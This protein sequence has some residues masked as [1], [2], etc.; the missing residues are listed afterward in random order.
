MAWRSIG[1]IYEPSA[2]HFA[3]HTH[4]SLPTAV[5]LGGDLVR[6]FYSGQDP[7][8]RFAIGS[9]VVRIGEAPVIE[10][11][12]A[13]PVL[14][15]GQVGAFDDAGCSMGCVVEISEPDDRLYYMGW[16]V[17]G[18]VPW[19]N[20]IGMALGDA[21]AGRFE[22]FSARAAAAAGVSLHDWLATGA[23]SKPAL[24]WS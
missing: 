8:N 21:R 9:L 12:V 7:A 16:N 17:G 14:T 3:L 19:R 22:R 20:A 6:V 10:E 13:A 1:R 11:V 23:S 15:P 5:S 4:A 18:S 24:R 2:P